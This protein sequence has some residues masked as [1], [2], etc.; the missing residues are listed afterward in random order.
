MRGEMS[1]RERTTEEA[2]SS[3]MK[4]SLPNGYEGSSGRYAPPA[5]HTPSSAT[6]NSDPRGRCTPTTDPTPA[7]DSRSRTAS[8]D[9]R[10]SSSP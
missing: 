2:A 3:S 7:P 10:A 1:P 9:E 8:L 6:I 5:F 4:A